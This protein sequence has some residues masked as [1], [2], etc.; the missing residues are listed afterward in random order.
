MSLSNWGAYWNLAGRV[1]HCP[2]KERKLN[3]RNRLSRELPAF[4]LVPHRY[5]FPQSTSRHFLF[6]ILLILNFAEIEHNPCTFG[7]IWGHS[8]SD[9]WW[10]LLSPFPTL[11]SMQTTPVFLLLPKSI[12]HSDSQ[13]LNFCCLSNWIEGSLHESHGS[14]L[15]C[16]QISAQIWHLK[17]IQAL[18][19]WKSLF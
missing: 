13:S 2:F 16:I 17:S 18:P 19:W 4:I 1:L 6:H 15:Q 12:K 14:F 9:P 11:I 8:W 3:S 10:L 7:I 5:V